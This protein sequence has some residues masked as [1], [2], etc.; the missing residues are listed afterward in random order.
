MNSN[1]GRHEPIS[2]ANLAILPFGS[3]LFLRIRNHPKRSC[4]EC[5][6][7]FPPTQTVVSIAIPG[8]GVGPDPKARE[9]FLALPARFTSTLEQ[10]R[11]CLGEVW[12]RWFN[13]ALPEDIFSVIKL[14]GFGLEN[15]GA[16]S[17]AWD[18]ASRPPA[19]NGWA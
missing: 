18:I 2:H 11:P 17:L 3:L 19:T 10:S 4:W 5:E 12:S 16:V 9:F 1:L 8:T 7:L 14:A 15:A 6:W 13:H